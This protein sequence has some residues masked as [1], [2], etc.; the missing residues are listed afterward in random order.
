MDIRQNLTRT[1]KEKK[2]RAQDL[3]KASYSSGNDL[4]RKELF[5]GGG[6]GCCVGDCCVGNCGISSGSST[7]KEDHAT[8][9]ASELAEMRRRTKK[10]SADEEIKIVDNVNKTMAEFI[11]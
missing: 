10:N 8:K 2:D 6:G 3:L 5:T 7:P 9:T 1:T 4:E 11:E